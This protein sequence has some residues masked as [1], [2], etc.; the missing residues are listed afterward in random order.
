MFAFFDKN[1]K[2]LVKFAHFFEFSNGSSYQTPECVDGYGFRTRTH[3][4]KSIRTSY[5]FRTC[6]LRSTRTSYVYAHQFQK[7]TRTNYCYAHEFQILTRTRTLQNPYI[8]YR[9]RIPYYL[10]DD[11]TTC[12][13]YFIYRLFHTKSPPFLGEHLMRS[14]FEKNGIIF[15]IACAL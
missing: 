9:T 7:L 5:V 6:I 4:L 11:I 13:K 10:F 8:K 12:Q 15:N 14:F 1:E 2:F 3:I